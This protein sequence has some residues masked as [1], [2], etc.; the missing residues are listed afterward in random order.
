MRGMR[1]WGTPFEK[2]IPHAPT[3]NFLKKGIGAGEPLPT[4]KCLFP[5]HPY[6]SL[7]APK[8]ILIPMGQLNFGE[9]QG[10]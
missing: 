6:L 7:A 8:S 5:R 4:P 9:S 10:D 3:E 2:G 1:M